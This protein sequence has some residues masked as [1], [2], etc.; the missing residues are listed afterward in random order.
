MYGVTTWEVDHETVTHG[1]LPPRVVAAAPIPRAGRP[2]LVVLSPSDG[3]LKCEGGMING[4]RVPIRYERHEGT[5]ACFLLIPRGT[6]G[7]WLLWSCTNFFTTP[8]VLHG[9]DPNGIPIYG[10]S[11]TVAD[12]FAQR[13]RIRR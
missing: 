10:G 3:D 5:V 13:T 4:N 11:S 8:A 1:S 6:A 12:C 2:F 7:K 9:V